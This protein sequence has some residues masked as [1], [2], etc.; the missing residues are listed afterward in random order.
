MSE[1][2]TQIVILGGMYCALELEKALARGKTDALRTD[3]GQGDQRE[4]RVG[5]EEKIAKKAATA[6]AAFGG[7]SPC[8][9]GRS[10][11]CQNPLLSRCETIYL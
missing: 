8:G 3:C 9:L 11:L 10:A 2:R 6:V 4:C 1:K 5:R 7:S